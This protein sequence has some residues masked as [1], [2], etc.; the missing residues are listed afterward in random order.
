MSDT[1]AVAFNALVPGGATRGELDRGRGRRLRWIE[2][3]SG[4]PTVVLETGAGTTA[5][6][7][8][9]ILPAL[10]GRSRVI[11][12]DRSGFGASDLARPYSLDLQLGD[13]IAVLAEAAAGGP[14]VLVGHSWGGGLAQ[15]A[16]QERPDLISGLVL[17]DPGD[18]ETLARLP[19]VLIRKMVLGR[20]LWLALTWLGFGKGGLRKDIEADARAVSDDPEAQSRYVDAKLVYYS[21]RARVRT[22]LTREFRMIRKSSVEFGRRSAAAPLPDVPVTVLSAA[23]QE[24]FGPGTGWLGDLLTA[25]HAELAAS[26]NRGSHT[27]VEDSGH[28]IHSDQ[29]AAVIEAVTEVLRQVQEVPDP[30]SLSSCAGTSRITA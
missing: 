26:V 10:A 29:P 1:I 12:Y 20:C 6:T 13:L 30:R 8:A 5:L 2:A 15:L 9:P 4:G 25:R 19:N 14:C 27:V 22:L 21:T 28:F 11:A 24:L 17:I 23:D 16:A 3:G 7:W 18:P